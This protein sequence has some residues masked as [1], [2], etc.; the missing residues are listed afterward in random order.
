MLVFH[1]WVWPAPGPAFSD[2]DGELLAGWR[3]FRPSLLKNGRLFGPPASTPRALCRSFVRRNFRAS[4]EVKVTLEVVTPRN[5]SQ[6]GAPLAAMVAGDLRDFPV[7]ED[8]LARALSA[9]S[10]ILSGGGGSGVSLCRT[11]PLSCR[12]GGGGRSGDGVR[13]NLRWS[14]ARRC[15][16]LPALLSNLFFHPGLFVSPLRK[17]EI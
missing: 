3:G 15:P 13:G 2:S 16:L 1:H 14:P 8:V 11:S 7:P 10:S 12:G 5:L 9:S 6:P 17:L 4:S